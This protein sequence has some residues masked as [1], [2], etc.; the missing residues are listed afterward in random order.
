MLSQKKLTFFTV[1]LGSFIFFIYLILKIFLASILSSG[2]V[3]ILGLIMAMILFSIFEWCIDKIS[4]R[5]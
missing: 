2:Y 3:F 1:I 4:M 5:S